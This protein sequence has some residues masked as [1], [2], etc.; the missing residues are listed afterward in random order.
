MWRRK[1]GQGKIRDALL[2]IVRQANVLL[3][4]Y[5]SSNTNNIERAINCN[6]SQQRRHG[7]R[8]KGKQMTAFHEGHKN[9]STIPPFVFQ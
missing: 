6:K 7:V 8:G 4:N 5:R 9:A 3:R 2:N 1:P